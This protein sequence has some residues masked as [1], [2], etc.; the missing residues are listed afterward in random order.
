MPMK[1]F[2]P[3][4]SKNSRWNAEAS[5]N[6]MDCRVGRRMLAL[7]LRRGPIRIAANTQTRRLFSFQRASQD[8]ATANKSCQLPPYMKPESAAAQ[9]QAVGFGAESR[10]RCVSAFQDV[11]RTS[12]AAPTSEAIN[13]NA[14][15]R[16]SSRW[17]MRHHELIWRTRLGP[18]Q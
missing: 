6:L 7:R 2:G 13:M 8:A 16:M 1:S 10:N 15:G 9:I 4:R 18:A 17:K 5:K 12:R 11:E 14:R 3:K